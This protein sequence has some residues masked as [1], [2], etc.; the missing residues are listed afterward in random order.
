MDGTRVKNDEYR[1]LIEAIGVM[2]AMRIGMIRG[3]QERE[4]DALFDFVANIQVGALDIV[5]KHCGKYLDRHIAD[6]KLREVEKGKSMVKDKKVTIVKVTQEHI[7]LS[8]GA[9]IT[10]DHYQDCCEQNYA[11]FEAIADRIEDAEFDEPIVFEKSGDHGF[12]F[13]NPGNMLYVPCY[14]IQNGYYS[15]AVDIYYRGQEVV[16]TTG[17]DGGY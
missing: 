12:R 5:L 1:E 15:N 7:E 11:D 17:G 4:G 14:S 9:L 16:N 3:A 10:Y 6:E 13:G 8:N 2:K